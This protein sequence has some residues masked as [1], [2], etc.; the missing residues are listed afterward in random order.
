MHGSA[1]SLHE[2]T[3]RISIMCKEIKMAATHD[4]EEKIKTTSIYEGNF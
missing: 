2:V 3:A 4:K 1:L